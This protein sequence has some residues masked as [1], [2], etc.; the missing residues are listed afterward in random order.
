VTRR[1]FRLPDLGEG[2]AEAEIVRWLVAPGDRVELNQPLVEVE[3]A[4]AVVELPSPFAGRLVTTEGAEGDT[5]MVGAVL[6]TVEDGDGAGLTAPAAGPP[7]PG[8]S[9]AGGVPAPPPTPGGGVE[10]PAAGPGVPGRAG[11]EPVLVGYGPRAAGV[12]AGRGRRRR[13]TGGQLPG[14]AGQAA[15]V[16]PA[17]Q[18]SPAGARTAAGGRPAPAKPPVRRL[19]RDLGVDLN[20]LTGTGPAGTISR[21]DVEA[22]A[23]DL[24]AALPVAGLG[25]APPA[26]LGQG[27][28]ARPVL[29][30]AAP[31][32]PA[33]GA[34]VPPRSPLPPYPG[35]PAP[36]R[37]ARPGGAGPAV[38][39]L[40]GGIPASAVHDEATRTWTVPVAG[41]RKATARAMVSSAFTAPH[42]T[43]FVAVDLTETLAALDRIAALPEF[44]GVRVTPLLLVAKALLVAVRRHPMVNA[45]WVDDGIGDP[46]IVVSEA[47]NLGIAVASARGLLV[48]NIPDAGRLDLAALARA[49]D[50]LVQRTR[51]GQ[52]SPSD[53]T[54]GTVTITNIGVFG[55][56]I[57]TPILNP[58]EAAILAVG[59]IRRAPWVHE[60]QL[61]VRSVCQLALSFDHRLIDGELGS[62]VLADVA[63]MVTEPTLLLAWS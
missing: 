33:P 11:R 24:G 49:L 55:V 56:D 58:G 2:L 38:P 43:E 18:P 47:V 5:I 48:P 44:A 8:P 40:V 32:A 51:A 53:V 59:A 37:G 14:G 26:A 35:R 4:K 10:P 20:R 45:T 62:A 60:D 9:R 46:R 57:G 29:N 16:M 15:L 54:G 61:A 42:V 34:T 12:A 7:E 30:G 52:V 63:A 17:G 25:G 36:A 19:A 27:G 21:A 39:G 13:H 1:E 23:H 31:A 3:T 22:A 28:A 50:E 41:V 6:V